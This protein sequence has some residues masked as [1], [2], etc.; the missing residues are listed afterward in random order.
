M[1]PKPSRTALILL[2]AV[3]I[4]LVASHSTEKKHTCTCI[5]EPKHGDHAGHDHGIEGDHEEED[6]SPKEILKYK[7]IA[8]V[9]ILV[10][11]A[12]GVFLPILGRTIPA[13][14][15]EKGIFYLIK[16]FAAGI[17]LSTA[18]IHI[19][20]EVYEN[21][22]SPCLGE[23]TV[24]EKF[25][26]SG[27]AIMA[28]ALLTLMMDSFA[29]RHF[30]KGVSIEDQIGAKQDMD[31]HIHAHGAGGH[32][33]EGLNKVLEIGIVVHSVI[34]GLSM[35]TSDSL[36]SIKSLIAALCFH[37]FF[38][39]IG[40]GGC[41]VQASFK[42]TST[43]CMAVFFSLTTPLGIAVGIGISKVYEE[44]SPTALIVQGLLN[45]VAAGI[46]INMALV[47]LLA[48]D[49]MNPKVQS[50]A[51]IFFGANIALL[52]GVA[53]MAIMAIWA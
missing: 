44:S 36:E 19:L 38:E 40:L 37:Q 22:T 3:T 2:F 53:A 52:L 9:T 4:K 45:A 12:V 18:F 25:P 46:L 14:R 24:W 42:S 28:G 39:G 26:F 21:L 7:V 49:L 48:E 1:A 43:I 20:P 47:N 35:G 32:V 23:D 33:P 27:L 29:T 6:D 16:S 34:I 15:P 13:L 17:I 30:R 41:I 11:S 10:T 31:G 51:K 5:K 8:L 50:K